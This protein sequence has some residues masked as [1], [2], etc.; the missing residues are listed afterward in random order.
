MQYYNQVFLLIGGNI[1][2]RFEY[3]EKAVTLIGACCGETG[4]QSPVYET[5]AWGNTSQGVFLNQALELHTS[6]EP[7]ELMKQLLQIEEKMG[8]IRTERY[9]PRTIDIDILLFN[10][11]II[12]T[13]LITVPHPELPK[14][15]FALQPLADIAGEVEHPALRKTIKTLLAECPDELPV[16]KVEA[17]GDEAAGN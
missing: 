1:G 15:R 13:P 16:R 12:S 11:E 10:N 2:N 3:L 6:A 7:A 8:R 14:R 4:L 5:A 9:G 17:P